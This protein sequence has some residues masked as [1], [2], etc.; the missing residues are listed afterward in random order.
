MNIFQET[1]TIPVF[2]VCIFIGS[3][4]GLLIGIFRK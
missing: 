3:Y 4:I 1:V 2:V